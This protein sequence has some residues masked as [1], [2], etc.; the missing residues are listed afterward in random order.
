L[1]VCAGVQQRFSSGRRLLIVDG[2]LLLKAKPTGTHAIPTTIEAARADKTTAGKWVPSVIVI[3]VYVAIGLVSHWSALGDFSSR[4]FGFTSDFTMWAWFESWVPHALGH[5]LNP[6]FSSSLYVPTGVN[7]AQNTQSPLLGAISAPFA[8]VLNPVA[9]ANLLVLV[10]MPISA[11]AA[12]IVLRVWKVWLPAAALGGLIY[13]FS[14]YMVSQGVA[15]IFLVFVPLPP[16]I[17]LTVVS[18]LQ[19]R[20]DSRRLG[21][22]LGLLVAAQFLISP[23]VLTTVA[24][25]TVVAIAAAA[26][27]RPKMVRVKMRAVVGPTVFAL[28]V[29]VV[30]LAYPIWM[31]LLGPQHFSGSTQP[32]SNPFY[33]DALS[34]AVPSPA[35]QLSWGMR[36]IG[37]RFLGGDLVEAGGFIGIPLLILCSVF[38][39][40]SR[41]RPR[42]RLTIVVLFAAG[43]LSLGPFLAVNGHLTH[44][45]LPSWILDHLPLLNNVLPS[46]FSF[47]LGAGIAALVAFG[48]DDMHSSAL[49]TTRRSPRQPWL[50]II[51]W[52]GVAAALL[53]T[54]TPRW[55]YLSTPAAGLPPAIN[56][57]IPSGDPIAITYPFATAYDMQPM[58]WQADDNFAFQLIGGYALH[59]GP[60]GGVSIVP[61]PMDP[62]ELQRF[63]ASQDG[64]NLYGRPLPLGHELVAATKAAVSKYKIREAIVDRSEQG[65]GPVIE[66]FNAA[67]GP[68]SRS[69]GQFSLWNLTAVGTTSRK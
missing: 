38:M 7:L 3:A 27:A 48:L 64:W 12:F 19:E 32:P 43:L 58:I 28:A 56:H 21:L 20:G 36:A 63:L 1:A 45:P 34:F 9:R 26:A 39:W 41:Q 31:M 42:M 33:N 14:P 62:P 67:F 47:E 40:R 44:V 55:P 25:L 10:A 16:F 6:L 68:P 53:V 57:A 49:A 2:R 35:Q 18:V 13:G 61:S 60:N 24:I 22:Q 15:H 52:F 23:E 8:L 66:L 50:A 17:A 46:R 37:A 4:F 30:L 11:T 65:S 54:Q 5:G 59:P 69:A 51:F 29:S